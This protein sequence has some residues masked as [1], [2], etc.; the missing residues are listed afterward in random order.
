MQQVDSAST[1]V[2]PLR[3]LFIERTQK[4]RGDLEQFIR[5]AKTRVDIKQN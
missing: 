5:G 1:L 3:A 4:I 2:E